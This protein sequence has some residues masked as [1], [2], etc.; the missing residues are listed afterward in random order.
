[1]GKGV[2][3]AKKMTCPECG[4]SL[5]LDVGFESCTCETCGK[6]FSLEELKKDLPGSAVDSSGVK[7]TLSPGGD[8]ASGAVSSEPDEK[9]VRLEKRR[10][11]TRS[12]FLTLL[13]VLAILIPASISVESANS[14]RMPDVVGMKFFDAKSEI[15]KVSSKWKVESEVVEVKYVTPRSVTVVDGVKSPETGSG[16][17]S[18]V[19]LQADFSDYQKRFDRRVVVGTVPERGELLSSLDSDQ[20]VILKVRETKIKL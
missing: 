9:V 15:E 17:N 10:R 2:G 4:G 6:T 8:G 7:E 3:M 1:M 11:R 5:A 16:N 19:H 14:V 20:V 12:A 18:L 13:I